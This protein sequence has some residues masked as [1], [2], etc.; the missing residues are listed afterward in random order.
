LSDK[1]NGMRS[2]G[3]RPEIRPQAGGAVIT[4]VVLAGGQA[5]RM[6]G[7]DKGLVTF[8]GRPLVEWVIA[9][10]APQVAAL[11][12]NANRNQ[13]AYEALGYPVIADQIE[14]F[15]GPLAGFASA[16]AA[17]G[18]PWIVTVPCDGPFLAP[19][20]VERLCAALER[21][22]AEI[23]VAT[24][25]KRM[26]PVYALLPVALAPSLHAFLAAGERKIDLWY[27][28]H[29]VALADLSDRPESFANINSEDD[30][31]L[32]QAEVLP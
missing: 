22:G 29:H 11:V 30:V 19:D 4:G 5:R 10:L 3:T 28:R 12:V 16:M 18:T 17:A 32:L 27:A 26:Q 13:Q 23:A 21:E 1:F 2:G 14:G 15:Q 24:D 31:A 25:G 6:G 9:A 20:L 8:R 7:Q